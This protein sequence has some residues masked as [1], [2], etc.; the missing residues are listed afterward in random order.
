MQLIDTDADLER[1]SAEAAAHAKA[2]MDFHVAAELRGDVPSLMES[3]AAD[4]P[5][6]YTFM[7]ESPVHPDG[8]LKLPLATTWQQ[9][10]DEYTALHHAVDMHTAVPFVEIVSEFYVF[11]EVQSLVTSKQT[12]NIT[13]SLTIAIFPCGTAKGIT[14]ELAWCQIPRRML[15]IGCRDVDSKPGAGVSEADRHEHRKGNIA[16]HQRY[17]EALR[18]GDV[19]GISEVLPDDAQAG[20]RDYADENLLVELEGRDAQLAYYARLFE[21]YEISSVELLRL[22]VQDWYVFSETRRTVT[23]RTGPEAGRSFVYRVA[24]FMIPGH[25][26]QFLVRLGTGTDPE[27]V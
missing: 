11:M 19:D 17:L 2:Q 9:V 27:A 18:A 12:G 7:K 4:E 26:G 23:A 22:V 15:G 1:R 5:Y 3:L 13:D 24:E 10:L 8:S 25:D 16:R 20:I 14:G 21:T 6:A